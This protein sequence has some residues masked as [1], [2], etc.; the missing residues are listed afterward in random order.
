MRIKRTASL[1]GL[2]ILIVSTLLGCSGINLTK[3]QEVEQDYTFVSMEE[4]AVLEYEVPQS[5]P[6]ILV[7]QLGYLPESTKQVFFFG[8]EIPQTFKVV[9][10]ETG[11]TVFSGKTQNRGYNKEYGVNISFGDFTELT[12]EGNYYVE[13]NLLGSSYCFDIADNIYDGIF[14]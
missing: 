4:E 1:A 13:A 11:V 12:K 9:N 10:S 3:E 5:S 14:N 7:D 6:H 2:G 8:K